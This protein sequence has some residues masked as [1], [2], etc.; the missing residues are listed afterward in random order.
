MVKIINLLLLVSLSFNC[1]AN[2]DIDMQVQQA[3]KNGQDALDSGF[4]DRLLKKN[5][6]AVNELSESY[7]GASASPTEISYKILI[8]ASMGDDEIKRLFKAYQYRQDVAFYIRGLLKHE[9]TITDASLRIYALVRDYK[10]T[11]PLVYLDPTPFNDVGAVVAPIIL[12]YQGNEL[13]LS[14][15]GLT[16]TAYMHGQLLSGKTGDLGS[17]GATAEI[18]ERDLT[19]IL[20]ER[21]EKLDTDKLIAEAKDNYWP[22]VKFL[23]LPEALATRQRKFVPEITLNADI[24][25]QE[26]VVIARRGDTFNTLE[27]MP[28]TQRVIIFDATNDDHIAFV[29]S[30]PPTHLRTK[31]ITTKFD[32]TKEWNAIKYVEALFNSPVY[33]LNKD[34]INAFD[35]R[36]LPTVIEADNEQDFFILSE[37]D[38]RGS[39]YE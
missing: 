25:T 1:N 28:F 9:K 8:S 10:T 37:F 36:V 7:Q 21:A 17:F 14:A 27:R 26:G 29:K 4:I 20:K 6:V 33:M 18:S 16:N 34:L 32:R 19:E 30:L 2:T 23:Q 12:A 3:I 39:E 35:L 5:N 31:L 22:K 38:V 15:T 11:P 13:M 24:V